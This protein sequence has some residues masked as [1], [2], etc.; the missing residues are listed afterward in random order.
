MIRG[1]RC[2]R[3]DVQIRAAGKTSAFLLEAYFLRRGQSDVYPLRQQRRGLY[4]LG[5]AGFDNEH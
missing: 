2:C 4:W 1:Q 5:E 3:S